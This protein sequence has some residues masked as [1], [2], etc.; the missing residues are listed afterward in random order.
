MKL[1][2]KIKGADPNDKEERKDDK[3]KKSV[4][5]ASPVGGGEL[6]ESLEEEKNEDEEE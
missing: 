3:A 1:K 2:R 5:F 4:A 6:D